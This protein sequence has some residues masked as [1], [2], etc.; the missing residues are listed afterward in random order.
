MRWLFPVIAMAYAF[1]PV[2]AV[3]PEVYGAPMPLYGPR[4]VPTPGVDE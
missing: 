3:R 2:W 4:W 1:A